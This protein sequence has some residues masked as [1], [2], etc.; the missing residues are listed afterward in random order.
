MFWNANCQAGSSIISLTVYPSFFRI[1]PIIAGHYKRTFKKAGWKFNKGYGYNFESKICG[2]RNSTVPIFDS[3]FTSLSKSNTCLDSVMS[4]NVN[5]KQCYDR[6][7]NSLTE[8]DLLYLMHSIDPKT[9]LLVV[10]Q[11]KCSGI[12]TSKHT[13]DWMNHVIKNSPRFRTFV[14]QCIIED[15]PIE[16][17]LDCK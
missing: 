4:P 3:A 14:S 1:K 17:F 9:R 8:N 6:I 13:S 15:K 12:E 5:N 11:I 2:F 16:Y 7:K 10:R